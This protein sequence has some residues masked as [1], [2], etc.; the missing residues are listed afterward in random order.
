MFFFKNYFPGDIPGGNAY[1]PETNSENESLDDND[2]NDLL[3]ASQGLKDSQIDQM[4]NNKKIEVSSLDLKEN[5]P[6]NQ[7][8][9]HSDLNNM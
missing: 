6:N 4:N 8:T 5:D 7:D 3:E 2:D 1:P 9:F